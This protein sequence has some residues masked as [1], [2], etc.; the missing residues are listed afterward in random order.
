[1]PLTDSF[2]QFRQSLSNQVQR[3]EQLGASRQDLMAGAQHIGDWLAREVNPQNPEQRLLK[4]MWSV[5]NKQ[6]QEAIASSL[7]KMARQG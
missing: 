1:M 7:L 6:E 4:E 2:E 5:A 3:A